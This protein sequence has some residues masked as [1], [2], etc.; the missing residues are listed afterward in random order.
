MTISS[1]FNIVVDRYIRLRA[2][3]VTI[4]DLFLLSQSMHVKKI[5]IEVFSSGMN[6]R[7]RYSDSL[8]NL[9]KG[10]LLY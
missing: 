10:R 7:L 1:L 8:L 4:Q 6:Q 5:F 2:I 9:P 3:V